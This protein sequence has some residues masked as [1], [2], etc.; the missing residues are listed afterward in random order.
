MRLSQTSPGKPA[1]SFQVLETSGPC[2][3]GSCECT[4]LA[5][6]WTAT[7]V[8]R[9]AG[10]LRRCLSHETCAVQSDGHSQAW[11]AARDLWPVPVE[12]HCARHTA[13]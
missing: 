2:R 13:F 12:M 5:P 4:C 6:S 11:S 7:L 8:M 1:R 3:Q 9:N 10:V